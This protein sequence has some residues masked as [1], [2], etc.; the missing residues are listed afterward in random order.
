M[1]GSQVGA[2]TLQ[3]VLLAALLAGGTLAARQFDGQLQ[4]GFG[5]V[6][7]STQD[8]ACNLREVSGEWSIHFV[9]VDLEVHPDACGR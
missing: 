4:Q 1:I 2:A 8:M 7:F 3:A 6:I 9:G 5:E